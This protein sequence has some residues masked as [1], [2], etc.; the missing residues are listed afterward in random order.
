MRRIIKPTQSKI[1]ERQLAYKDGKNDELRQLLAE[2]QHSICAYTETYLSSSDD[3]HI[4]HFDPTLKNTDTDSY[5]N[6]F[7]V[8]SLWNIRKSNKWTEPILHPTAEDLEQRILYFDGNYV[9]ADANDI[10]AQNLI[11]LLDLDNARLADQR[12]RYI[13][14]K[15]QQINNLNQ[16]SQQYIDEL[17]VDYPEGVYFIRALE[18][19]LQVKVNFDLVKTK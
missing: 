7:L 2:E 10:E 18:E 19:E 13:R 3:A 15:K 5:T 8:K 16:P 17:L 11:R 4:E 6:W 12:K 9:A 14:S 1:I